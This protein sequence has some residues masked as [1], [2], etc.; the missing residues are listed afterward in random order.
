MKSQHKWVFP[1]SL[2]LVC[3]CANSFFLAYTRP[4]W[5]PGLGLLFLIANLLPLLSAGDGAGARLR[6]C[7]HGSMC[8]KIVVISCLISAVFQLAAAF[9]L[10]R[11]IP[12]GWLWSVLVWILA[13]VI[14]F[15][16]GIL[17]VYCTSV[18]LGIR[19]RVIGI[20]CGWIPVANL[21][22]LIRIIRVCDEE[23]RFEYAKILLNE[24]RKSQQICRTK[25]PILF[26]H[27]VFF[28]DSHHLNYWGRIP[29]EITRNGG[30]VFYG[31][32]QSAASVAGSAHELT[33]RIQVILA[34]T[35]CEKVNIIAHSKGGLD[36]RY[37][38]ANT[39]AAP[40]VA[41]LTTINT[42]HRGCKFADYLLNVVP[43]STQAGIARAY[44]AAL[45]KL[46]D[47]NPD[48][49]AAVTDLTAERCRAL[50]AQMPVPPG[51]CCQSVG[52]RL[53]RATNGKFP[54]N[55]TFPLVKYFDGENDGLVGSDSFAWGDTYTYLTTP[56]KRGISHGDMIDLNRE[57][58]PGFDV[59]EFYVQ[60]VADLKRRGL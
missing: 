33:T 26:V 10:L 12:L 2:A 32:H 58:I 42:P 35:G 16:N 22:A 34:S 19:Q 25:Y 41:S 9:T 48:F 4:V 50:D 36:C 18:Q 60:L 31:N 44:N 23:V 13:E 57:N 47:P 39:G 59:R 53:N 30:Q 7:C 11:A 51:I 6:V 3:L 29:G 17:C 15:W 27:G 37:A 52:S 24:S 56:G 8:L 45:R 1:V 49:M 46:G 28:R 54:L 5:I 40:Y 14:L 21:I 38:L 20:L 43:Q 55:F